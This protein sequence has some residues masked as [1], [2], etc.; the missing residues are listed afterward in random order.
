MKESYLRSIVVKALKPLDAV[1]VENAVR[2]GTPDINFIEGWV[3]LKWVANWPVRDQTVLK[4]EHFTP[5]QRVWIMRRAIAGGNIWVL[6]RVEKEWLLLPGLWAS[7]N[8][9]KATKNQLLL[10]VAG[11][12][13]ARLDP[14]ELVAMLRNGKG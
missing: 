2:S 4:V 1:S 6:L 10:A 13:K 9:G 8:L 5:Q 11:Y 12:W 3:E 14:K 7:R